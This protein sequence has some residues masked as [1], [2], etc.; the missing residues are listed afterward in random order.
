MRDVDDDTSKGGEEIKYRAEWRN[1]QV[2]HK[3]WIIKKLQAVVQK[4][5]I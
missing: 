3:M 5:P 1:E 4:V 2:D